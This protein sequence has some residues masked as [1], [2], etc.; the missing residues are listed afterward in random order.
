MSISSEN[1]VFEPERPRANSAPSVT[2]LN[3]RGQ[4]HVHYPQTLSKPK[5]H[6]GLPGCNESPYYLL[7][8]LYN[9][10]ATSITPGQTI[11]GRGSR[12]V[13]SAGTRHLARRPATR[14]HQRR[15]TLGRALSISQEQKE[16]IELKYC[17]Y[18]PQLVGNVFAFTLSVCVSVF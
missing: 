1:I 4:G 17:Y 11:P 7:R 14:H 6:H 9:G 18:R 12:M 5:Y 13:T 15:G 3:T 10:N 16:K 2:A 8:S